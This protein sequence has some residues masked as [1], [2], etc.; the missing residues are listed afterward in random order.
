MAGGAGYLAEVA[1]TDATGVVAE[2]YA[3][4]KSVMGVP[5]VNLVYRYLAVRPNVLEAVWGGVR[6]HFRDPPT[7]TRIGR[8]VRVRSFGL[9]PWGEHTEAL[10]GVDREWENALADTLAL[11][12]YA[13]T[14]NLT[15]VEWALGPTPGAVEICRNS[16]ESAPS[17]VV[18]PRSLLPLPM[19]RLADLDPEVLGL[20]NEI[21]RSLGPEGEFLVVPSLFRH[22]TE[23]PAFLAAIWAVL[24]VLIRAEGFAAECLRL[25]RAAWSVVADVDPLRL[26]P[27]DREFLGEI[28]GFRELI[29]RMLFVGGALGEMCGLPGESSSG[30]A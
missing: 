10:L 4:I 3:D 8:A 16:G 15:M 1:E 23:R 11:Y 18:N 6:P 19:A 12:N 26:G 30:R 22:F 20:L 7:V 28:A 17:S 5:V 14:L 13:N 24:A 27:L 25:R 9:Q 21:A 2:I 29:P